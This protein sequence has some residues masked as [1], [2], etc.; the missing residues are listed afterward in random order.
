MTNAPYGRCL[1][2]PPGAPVESVTL[3]QREQK[4]TVR[5]GAQKRDPAHSTLHLFL[6]HISQ[7]IPVDVEDRGTMDRRIGLGFA[8]AIGVL[9][10]PVPF[11]SGRLGM[12][13]VDRG[14][15]AGCEREQGLGKC[16]FGCFQ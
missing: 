3:G 7:N 14:P 6:D 5:T 9:Q 1:R 15:V 8:L 11:D 12:V 10:C 4:K 13:V 2:C 16:G